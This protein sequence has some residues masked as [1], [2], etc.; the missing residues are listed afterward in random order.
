MLNYTKKIIKSYDLILGF[1]GN[2]SY[3]S[4]KTKKPTTLVHATCRRRRIT[5]KDGKSKGLPLTSPFHDLL[6]TY[7]SEFVIRCSHFKRK[8][9]NHMV[10]EV[11]GA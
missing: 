2:A 7:L 9:D 4:E 5:V 1:Q 10:G 11:N 8:T 3:K 6:A